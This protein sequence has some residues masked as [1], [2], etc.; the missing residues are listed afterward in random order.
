VTT[1]L[2]DRAIDRLRAVAAQAEPEP[3]RYT[4]LEEIGRGGMGIVYRARDEV[5]DREVAVKV[6][7]EAIGDATLVARLRRE[8]HVLASLEHPGIVPVHDAGT[9]PDGRAFYV[10]KLV[11]G[12]SLVDH[13]ASVT[14]LDERLGLFERICEAAA[15]A[16]DSGVVHRDIKPANV[17]V[18]RFGE[19]LV[20]DWGLAKA[21]G[22]DSGGAEAQER[23]SAEGRQSAGAEAQE[24]RSAEE[25]FVGSPVLQSAIAGTPGFMAPEQARGEAVGRAA[26]VHALGALLVWM[27]TG[28]PP[29]SSPDA[30]TASLRQRR[31]PVRLR[32]VALKALSVSPIDR[33]ADAAALAHDVARWRAGLTVTAHRETAIERIARFASTYR[34]PIL[35]VLAYL[36][37]RI[38]VAIYVRM[39]GG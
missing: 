7:A 11:R 24:R 22:A 37:M 4:L 27:L 30:T 17:M 26:D 20:L 25:P 9:L 31:V 5:L 29:S 21:V 36:V 10:M 18:G 32:S 38:L 13:L 19:V 16:H 14:R 12:A 39:S 23:R 34:T 33:Y 3:S 28:A 6:I 8:A 1:W 35:L 2:S 15:F